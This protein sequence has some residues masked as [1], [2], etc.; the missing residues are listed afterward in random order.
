MEIYMN[1]KEALQ[2]WNEF[3]PEIQKLI[4][5]ELTQYVKWIPVK[6]I[7][8]NNTT[9]IATVR[10]AYCAEDGSQDYVNVLNT[11]GIDLS[12]GD[13]VYIAYAYSPTNAIIV[14]KV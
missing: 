6:V 13:N 14:Y 11:T 1:N 4:Q 8:A 12:A 2:I 5:S 7:S 10:Q 9:K 3:K